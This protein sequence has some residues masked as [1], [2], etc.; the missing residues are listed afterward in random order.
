MIAAN[1]FRER[2]KLFVMYEVPRSP[3]LRGGALIGVV[4]RQPPRQIGCQPG[5]EASSRP[6]PKN[7]DDEHGEWRARRGRFQSSSYCALSRDFRTFRYLGHPGIS[8]K[9]VQPNFHGP[10]PPATHAA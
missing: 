2:W 9:L 8:I 1:G 5:V 7:V 6:A 3:M 10:A 4:L